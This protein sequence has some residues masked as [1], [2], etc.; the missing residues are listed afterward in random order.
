MICKEYDVKEWCGL[1]FRAIRDLIKQRK[2][3]EIMLVRLGEG[4]VKGIFG[5]DGYVPATGRPSNEVARLI[6]ERLEIL[7]NR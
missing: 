5:I 2:D 6:L 7:R 4:D 3:D 1:E